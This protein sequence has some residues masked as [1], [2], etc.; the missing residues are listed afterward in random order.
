MSAGS[1]RAIPV[2]CYNTW[3]YALG[4]KILSECSVATPGPGIALP[5]LMP[6]TGGHVDEKLSAVPLSECEAHVFPSGSSSTISRF[7]ERLE[8]SVCSL[9][10]LR[11]IRSI[12]SWQGTL[13]CAHNTYAKIECRPVAA[14][15]VLTRTPPEPPPPRTWWNWSAIIIYPALFVWQ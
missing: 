2:R 11:T 13:I 15:E 5:Q 4:G 7:M 8:A 14:E 12:P 6:L 10:S 9:S 1:I 3:G